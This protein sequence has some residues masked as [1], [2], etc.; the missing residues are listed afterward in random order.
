MRK[1][2]SLTIF[3]SLILLAG[4]FSCGK[5]VQAPDVRIYSITPDY[6]Q[7]ADST[8]TS[9]SVSVEIVNDVNAKVN[10]VEFFFQKENGASISGVSSISRVINKSVAA[11]GAVSVLSS[12]PVPTNEIYQY[13]INNPT[14]NIILRIKISGEDDYNYDK[15]WNCEGTVSVIL[16]K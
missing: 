7:V 15:E 2:I 13:M 9:V 3:I 5:L 4:I 11:G 6:I 12:Y 8:S 1:K 16:A 10:K 14:E